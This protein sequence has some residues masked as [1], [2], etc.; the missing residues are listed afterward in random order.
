MTLTSSS[1]CLPPLFCGAIPREPT[2]PQRT[3]VP[4]PAS[5]PLSGMVPTVLGPG[6]MKF[7]HI[8]RVPTL[9]AHHSIY[10]RSRHF[11]NIGKVIEHQI[12]DFLE[13]DNAFHIYS[14]C[15]VRD[16]NES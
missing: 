2:T 5:F 7:S 16:L 1:L 14:L 3:M 6:H 15:V 12:F 4:S 9:P 11:R 10:V 8:L 13:V